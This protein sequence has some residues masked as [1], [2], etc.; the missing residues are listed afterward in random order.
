M[1][2]MII[3]GGFLAP[4]FLVFGYSFWR[5]R[6]RRKSMAAKSAEESES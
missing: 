1:E 6:Q 5:S 4:V 3:V 2:L